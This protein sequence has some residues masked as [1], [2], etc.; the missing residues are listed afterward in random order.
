M[1][2][3]DSLLGCFCY[4]IHREEIEELVREAKSDIILVGDFNFPEIDWEVR[5]C[6]S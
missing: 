1:I 6:H 3:R 4:P 5:V 2:C